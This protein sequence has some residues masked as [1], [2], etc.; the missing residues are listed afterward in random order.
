MLEVKSLAS[1]VSLLEK[2]RRAH[3]DRER[4]KV[5]AVR[6]C[7]FNSLTVSSLQST[8]TKPQK[9]WNLQPFIDNS[10]DPFVP[11]LKEKV[12]QRMTKKSGLSVIEDDEKK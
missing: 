9:Q 4:S 7:A 5:V 1:N 12:N 6:I 2:L 8:I 10:S 11:K 3:E